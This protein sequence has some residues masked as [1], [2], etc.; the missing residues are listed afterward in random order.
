[1]DSSIEPSLFATVKLLT[2]IA[3]I[4]VGI[5]LGGKLAESLIVSSIDT[6]NATCSLG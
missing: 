4:L 3:R 6:L 5:I 2:V 1:M